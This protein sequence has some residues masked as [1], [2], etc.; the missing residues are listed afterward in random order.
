MASS[1]KTSWLLSASA[2]IGAIF[3]KPQL[4]LTANAGRNSERGTN[5]ERLKKFSRITE[6][7]MR[8]VICWGF[9]IADRFDQGHGRSTPAHELPSACFEFVGDEDTPA[10]P[11]K[12]IDVE[13]STYWTLIPRGSEN[14][15]D[16]IWH[17]RKNIA[18][19][20]LCQ[21]TALKIPSKLQGRHNYQSTLHVFPKPPPKLIKSKAS[22]VTIDNQVNRDAKSIM[23]NSQAIDSRR[24][25][26]VTDVG[27]V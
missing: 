22:T 10:P 25:F 17:S 6:M 26:A 15:P 20:N 21:I 9:Y 2:L 11:P 4:S 16:N 27:K 3:A 1:S 5:V 24:D 23:V 7:D 19:S 13:V 14:I 8:G 12:R 18:Y